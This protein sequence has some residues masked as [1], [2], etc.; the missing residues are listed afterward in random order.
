MYDLAG[1]YSDKITKTPNDIEGLKW[2][3]IVTTFAATCPS[4]NEGCQYILRDPKKV[5]EGLESRVSPDQ[6]QE[7]KELADSWIQDWKQRHK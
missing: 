1:M 6:Q 5:R 4:T 2:L 7:A 3:D